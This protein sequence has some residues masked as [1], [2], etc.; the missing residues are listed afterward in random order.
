M[1]GLTGVQQQAFGQLQLHARGLDLLL[2]E[3]VTQRVDQFGVVELAG[4]Q[5]DGDAHLAHA[6]RVQAVQHAA[7]LAHHPFADRHDQPG[8]LGQADEGVRREHALGGMLPAQQRFQAGQAVGLQAQLG[9][10]IQQQLVALDGVAQVVLDELAAMGF[11]IQLRGEHLPAVLAAGLGLVQ[12]QAGL[13][14]QL[15]GMAVG[16]DVAHQ[17]DGGGDV[18]QL[19]GHEQRT[20]EQVQQLPGHFLGIHVGGVE[21]GGELVAGEARQTGLGPQR[22]AQAPRQAGQHLVAGLVAEGLVDAFEVVDVHQQQAEGRVWR[23]AQ[24]LL[25]A[26]DE[27]GAIAQPGEAVAQGLL[28]LALIVQLVER[29]VLAQAEQVGGDPFGVADPGHPH[30]SPIGFQALALAAELHLPA[31]VVRLLA[32]RGAH[33]F[34]QAGQGG[35]FVQQAT[36]QFAGTVLGDG[37]EARVGE[38]HAPVDVDQQEGFGALFQ[39]ATTQVGGG[40]HGVT[41]VKRRAER[42]KIRSIRSMRCERFPSVTAESVTSTWPL[43]RSRPAKA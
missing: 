24:L 2:P 39:G 8:F 12:R 10:V 1:V 17:A 11:G 33:Q 32:Q 30:V 26:I 9:L 18:D 16:L 6:G 5:V 23:F 19:V 40:S 29:D 15:L 27:I 4:R 37:L 22:V 35:N 28:C 7:G 34:R 20:A 13:L 3:N 38:D 36:L 25:E 43:S 14:H 21:Q 41:W 42:D 31:V